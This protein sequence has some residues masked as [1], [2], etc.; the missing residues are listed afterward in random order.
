[1]VPPTTCGSWRPARGNYLC[2]GGGVG[3]TDKITTL[4]GCSNYHEEWDFDTSP[5]KGG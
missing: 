5:I 2:A 3:S 1:M 4:S